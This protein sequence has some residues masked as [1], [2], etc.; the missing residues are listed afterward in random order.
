MAALAPIVVLPQVVIAVLSAAV[1]L[2]LGWLTS[3]YFDLG[4]SWRLVRSATDF[5][6]LSLAI[7]IFSRLDILFISKI[8]GERATGIYNAAY[9]VARVFSLGATSYSQAIYPALS[10]LF[11]SAPDRFATAGRQALRY[12]LIAMLPAVVGTA[13][14]AH[15]IIDL[16]YGAEQYAEAAPVMQI[17]IWL[18]I[19]FLVS[20][21]LSRLLLAGEQQRASLQ[22]AVIRLVVAGLYFLL[23]TPIFR[24]HGAAVATLISFATGAVLNWYFVVHRLA[25]LEVRS[26]VAKPFIATIGMA[27]VVLAVAH[28]GLVVSIGVGAVTYLLLLLLLRTFDGDDW[29]LLRQL[30]GLGEAV[31][32]RP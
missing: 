23:L 5:Y 4:F 10:R 12:G 7:A 31:G 6:L 18:C 14:L 13:V 1:V 17:L 24:V 21:L 22:V 27:V 20:A 26:L 32:G 30:A 3:F 11:R 28:L 8:L 15:T 25:A 29:L 16:I 9:Q 19:P 2:R